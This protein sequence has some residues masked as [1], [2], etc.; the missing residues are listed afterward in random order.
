MRIAKDNPISASGNGKVVQATSGSFGSRRNATNH[1]S[2]T[3]STPYSRK[4]TVPKS[5][6]LATETV[7][8]PTVWR[9]TNSNANV[10]QPTDA[11]QI[12][13]GM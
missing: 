2:S 8:T 10:S 7:F 9:W 4:R 1:V 12:R 3:I 6:T 11:F 5:K 13:N